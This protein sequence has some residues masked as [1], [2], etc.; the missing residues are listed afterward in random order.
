MSRILGEFLGSAARIFAALAGGEADVGEFSRVDFAEFVYGTYGHGFAKSVGNVFPEL[1]RVDGLDAIMLDASNAS[2]KQALSNLQMLIDSLVRLCEC[3]ICKDLTN[4]HKMDTTDTMKDQSCILVTTV[5]INSLVRLVAGTKRHD[6]INPTIAGL[7]HLYGQCLQ[8]I[9]ASCRRNGSPTV[10]DVLGLRLN[11]DGPTGYPLSP[12]YL[13][14]DVQC[15]FTVRRPTQDEIHRNNYRTDFSY[16]GI[17]CYFEVLHGLSS[18][19]AV[20]RRIHVLPG[21]IQRGDRE[22]TMVWDCA[23]ASQSQLPLPK[24]TLGAKTATLSSESRDDN[25]DIKAL[26]TEESGG[27]QLIFY[28]QALL[29]DARVVRIRP[30]MLTQRVMERSGLVVCDKLT[31]NRDLVFP[32]QVI[33]EGWDVGEHRT[34]SGQPAECLI[35]PFREDDIGRCVATEFAQGKA[36][37]IRQG[38]CLPYE[39]CF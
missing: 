25:I 2:F 16:N 24:V 20:L 32:C 22:Y 7:Q 33:C 36:L 21:R 17:C 4:R 13:M 26:V 14:A 35:W 1:G 19:A 5:A 23:P 6:K 37:Y 38:E 15:L 31:C 34:T 8:R 18:N 28:Y 3:N 29:Q 10:S 30:G 27:G 11:P 39:G 9:E 12:A